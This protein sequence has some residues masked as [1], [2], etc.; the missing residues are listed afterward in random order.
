MRDT[1][2]G[3]TGTLASFGLGE[4]NLVIGILAGILTCVYMVLSIGKE[5]RK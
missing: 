5:V 3:I 2:V 1:I 4:L